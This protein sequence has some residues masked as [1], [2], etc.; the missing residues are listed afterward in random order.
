[1]TKKIILLLSFLFVACYLF[2][3]SY[4]VLYVNSAYIRIGNRYVSVGDVFSD[5]ETIM[6]SSDQ[7]A[8]K[9]LN[10]RS[11]K[12]FACTAKALKNKKSHSLYDYLTSTRRISTRSLTEDH[13]DEMWLFDSKLYLID[14]LYISMPYHYSK[15]IE[16]RIEVFEEDFS[17]EIPIKHKDGSYLITRDLIEGL[18]VTPVRLNIIEYDKEREWKYA[19]YKD[20]IIELL[21]LFCD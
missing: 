20:L 5:R 12:V 11:K 17:R 16:T 13:L 2:A 15:S 19:V 21:P 1:M 8:M 3:D 14:T 18:K 10:T 6:W 4:K 9:V 7:Q